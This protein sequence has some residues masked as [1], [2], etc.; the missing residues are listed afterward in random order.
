M[1]VDVQTS[2]TFTTSAPVLVLERSYV[3]NA[4]GLSAR[5]YDVSLDGRRFLMIKDAETPPSANAPGLVAVVN[6]FEELRKK[7]PASR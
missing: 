7:V 3:W 5:T 4:V 1:R 6:W 2:P